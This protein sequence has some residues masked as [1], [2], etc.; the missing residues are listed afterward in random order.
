MPELAQAREAGHCSDRQ[1]LTN[2]IRKLIVEIISIHN[3]ELEAVIRGDAV[4]ETT[5][6]RPLDARGIGRGIALKLRNPALMSAGLQR[7]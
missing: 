5:P 7:V 1:T 3:E 2:Q 6:K 4:Y